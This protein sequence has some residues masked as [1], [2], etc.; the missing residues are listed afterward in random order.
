M[1][2]TALALVASSASAFTAL[3]PI[4][5]TI[6]PNQLRQ[7]RNRHLGLGADNFGGDSFFTQDGDSNDQD[8]ASADDWFNQAL[9]GNDDF[10][11]QDGDSNVQDG[12]SADD[13]FGMALGSQQTDWDS[14]AP[15]AGWEQQGGEVG[16]DEYSRMMNSNEDAAETAEWG[17]EASMTWAGQA[18]NGRGL[19]L[20]TIGI[21]LGTTN[22]LC[23]LWLKGRPT[24]VPNKENEHLTPSVVSFLS[25]GRKI[26]GYSVTVGRKAKG[27]ALSN[28]KNTFA[29]VKRIIG[30]PGEGEADFAMVGMGDKIE[31][32]LMPSGEYMLRAPAISEDTLLSPVDISSAVVRQLIGNAAHLFGGEWQTPP[33]A[34][35]G[36]PARFNNYQRDATIRAC[37][38]AGLE[39]VHLITEPEAA[40]LAF[41]LGRRESGKSKAQLDA[42]R[43]DRDK[44]ERT[45]VVD[46]GGGTF[47]VSVVD[48]KAD[49]VETV[50]VGG[51]PLLGG[52]DF[53]EAF[54]LFLADQFCDASGIRVGPFDQASGMAWNRLLSKAEEAR[55]ELSSSTSTTISLADL[56]DGQSFGPVCVTRREFE[57]AVSALIERVEAGIVSTLTNAAAFDAERGTA[58]EN[59]ALNNAVLVGGAVR[60]PF[61]GRM[62]NSVTGVAPRRTVN[63]D[64][65]I[66]LGCAV[67]GAYLDGLVED[68]RL[69]KAPPARKVTKTDVMFEM[70]SV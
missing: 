3:L 10:F 35:I 43:L 45:L 38:S 32:K 8:G 56:S 48:V 1:H 25:D 40:A 13:W 55:I 19:H 21:D 41:G 68:L 28:P 50:A 15:Q 47:D 69:V 37:K 31:A 23:A 57:S 42:A 52:V 14:A 67:E 7:R 20:P 11:N 63:P 30:R 64:E 59:Q 66:A 29:S 17:L 62:V 51:D 18:V 65:A 44:V 27:Q 2:W 24:L 12:A 53:D 49:R 4:S 34:V 39:E 22:S 26:E 70:Y 60:M 58:L 54:A 36:V 6:R 46:L 5:H 9:A 61:I 16:D 33:R